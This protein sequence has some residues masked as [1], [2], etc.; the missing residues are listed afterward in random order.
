MAQ[1]GP[2]NGNL[3]ILEGYAGSRCSGLEVVQ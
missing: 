1:Q 3:V 2:G